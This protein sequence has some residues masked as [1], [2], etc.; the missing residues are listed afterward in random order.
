MGDKVYANSMSILHKGSAGKSMAT[1][2]DTCLCPPTPPAGPIPTPLPNNA[3]ASDLVDGASSVL[4]EG[5]PV[6][7]KKSN[8]SKSTGN[9][10]SKPTGGGVVTH[11]TQGKAQFVS[12]SMDVKAEGEGVVRHLDMCTHN[13]MATPGNTPPWPVIA[14]MGPAVLSAC[15]ET[16]KDPCQLV[17]YDKG[18]PDGKTPHHVMS[19]SFFVKR[20]MRKLNAAVSTFRGAPVTEADLR[21]SCVEGCENYRTNKAPCV[22]VTGE[23]KN[24]KDSTGKLLQHGRIHRRLDLAEGEAAKAGGWCY[25]QARDA[26]AQSVSEVLPECPAACIAAQLDEHHMTQLQ[27]KEPTPVRASTRSEGWMEKAKEEIADETQVTKRR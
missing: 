6:G 9:E 23:D 3:M 18:C 17:P 10:T 25:S 20:G 21:D 1:F 4:I 13:H 12:Q 2:P 27:I 22:C 19:S 24:T 15:G 16:P 8:L 14:M 26:A 5:N 7:T 11:T